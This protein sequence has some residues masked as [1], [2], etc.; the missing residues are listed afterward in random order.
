MIKKLR[1]IDV[2]YGTTHDGPGMRTTVFV[3]GCPLRCKWCQNP[4]SI[5]VNNEVWWDQTKCI[6]CR[7]C[8][9]SCSSGAL[10][11]EENGLRINRSICLNCGECV[12][13]CPAGALTR[14]AEEYDLQTLMDDVLKY[15]TYYDQFGGGVTCSG[16]EPLL[17]YSFIKEFFKALHEECITTAL[18]TCGCVP[19]E[20]LEAVLPYTDYILYD[21]KLFDSKKHAYFTGSE[22]KIIL[23]NLLYIAEYVRTT[24]RPME[25]WI[26]TPLIPGITAEEE[27]IRDIGMFIKENLADVVTRWELCAFNG[28]CVVKYR[29]LGEEWIYQ[30][31]KQMMQ[32]EVD[33]LHNIANETFIKEKI[34]VT[35]MIRPD[36]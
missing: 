13:A 36:N 21:I 33:L 1:V 6:G 7:S 30:D 26:R 2:S 12:N 17:Q 24:E 10:K 9:Q 28:A 23:N 20:N 31:I 18:D 15:R 11:E 34:I 32:S 3:K 4:E 25:V 16:G 22:N 8:L 19:R 14:V 29:K 27:T 35:G 5:R